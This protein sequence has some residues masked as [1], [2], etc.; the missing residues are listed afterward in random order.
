MFNRYETWTA[1]HALVEYRQ[2]LAY[3]HRWAVHLYELPS[4][5]QY[6]PVFQLAILTRVRHLRQCKGTKCLAN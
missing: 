2:T 3:M 6:R 4:V 5:P 1:L